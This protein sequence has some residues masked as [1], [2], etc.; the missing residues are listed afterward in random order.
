M[1]YSMELKF[2]GRGAAFNPVDGNNSAYFI[3]NDELFLIDCGESIFERIIKLNI[4]KGIRSVNVLI[5]HTHSDHIGSIGS[6]IMYCFYNLNLKINIIL[7]EG[8]KHKNNIECILNNFGCSNDMYRYVDEKSY[9]KKYNAFSAIRYVETRHCKELNCYGIIFETDSGIVYYSGDTNDVNLIKKIIS[10][11]NIN[12]MYIDT[13]S[14]DYPNNVHLYVGILNE[15][16]PTDLKNKVYCMH[17]NDSECIA[18]VK[19]YG[20]NIVETE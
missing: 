4:L 13:T 14:N 9:N 18:L 8:A 15:I 20:F 19:K 2:L 7:C 1:G 5:T 10:E 6:L 16:I 12:K 11:N 17:I 3:E